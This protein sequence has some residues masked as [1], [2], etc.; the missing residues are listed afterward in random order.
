MRSFSKKDNSPF[1]KLKSGTENEVTEN[2]E[3]SK[4]LGIYDPLTFPAIPVE[5]GSVYGSAVEKF[6]VPAVPFSEKHEA[7][8]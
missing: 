5:N 1:K 4:E 7:V 6:E 3:A 2:E 8:N